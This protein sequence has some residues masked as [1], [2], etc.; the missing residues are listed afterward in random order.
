[1]IDRAAH[2]MGQLSTMSGKL[3]IKKEHDGWK[4]RCPYHNGGNERTPSCKVNTSRYPGRY[5]CFGCG[6]SGPWNKLALTLNLQGFKASDQVNDVFSFVIPEE[7]YSLSVPGLEKV[8]DLDDFSVASGWRTITLDT[9]ELFRAKCPRHEYYNQS[10]WVYFPVYRGKNYVG[11]VYARRV[12]TKEG[13][14]AGEL[15][16]INTKGTWS[17]QNL[18]GYNIA[19]RRKGPLWYV[20]GPRDCMKIVQLGGR[21][22]AGLGSFVGPQKIALIQALDP[23]CLIIGTDPDE[24]GDKARKYL[25]DNLDM[26][27]TYDAVFPAGKDP[28]DLTTRRL[29]KMLIKLGLVDE[30]A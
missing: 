12:V 1:M 24:A 27:P 25:K 19:K 6:A 20:E 18:F 21:A 2:V 15:S 13:K 3:A 26:L 23:P 29:E 10:K 9:L 30:T 16:Y 22:V 7:N 5:T 17:K 14:D 28:A 4:I 8:E 11:G